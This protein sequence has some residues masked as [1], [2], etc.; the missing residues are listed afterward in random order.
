[1]LRH[2]FVP[3]EFKESVVVPIIKDKNKDIA[4]MDNYRGITVASVVSKLL[5]EE[6]C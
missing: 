3:K 1:M 5:R 4:N 2:S 6:F